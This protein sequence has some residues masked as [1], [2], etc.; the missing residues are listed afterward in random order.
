GWRSWGGPSVRLRGFRGKLPQNPM[1]SCRTPD[2]PEVS[3]N[4]L[5]FSDLVAV[6]PEGLEPPTLCSEG[7]CSIQLSYGCA[8]GNVD[9]HDAGRKAAIDPGS[10][11]RGPGWSWPPGFL[12]SAAPGYHAGMS[13]GL[14]PQ[15]RR[16]VEH[17]GSSVVLASGAG[18]GKTHVLTARYLSHL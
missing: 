6:H 10:R 3:E 13:T 4:R 16:A 15:Q 2:R 8:T 18:C 1:G 9:E 17:R 11:A 14:T 12:P 7:K 5:G